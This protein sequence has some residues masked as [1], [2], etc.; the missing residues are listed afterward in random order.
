M[1]F[2]LAIDDAVRRSKLE[3]IYS[4]YKREL[5]ITAFSMVRNHEVAED[6]VQSTIIRANDNLEKLTDIR[7]KKT[8]AYL[9]TIVKNLCIDYFKEDSVNGQ[10]MKQLKKKHAIK[11]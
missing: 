5:Y 11:N 9:I 8:R 2:L 1:I 6:I 4:L 10:N 3:E 7:S